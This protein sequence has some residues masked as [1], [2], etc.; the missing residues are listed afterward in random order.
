M[1]FNVLL[2]PVEGVHR[3]LMRRLGK[4]VDDHPK[5]VK[6]AVGEGRP[7]MKF[8]LMSSHFQAGIYSEIVAIQQAS[9]DQP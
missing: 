5:G 1:Q 9:Y 7:T 8:I 3:N 2:S 6:L 4:L